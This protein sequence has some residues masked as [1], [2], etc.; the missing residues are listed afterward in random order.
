MSNIC[1]VF[2]ISH[3]YR[4]IKEDGILLLQWKYN[5][6]SYFFG[7]AKAQILWVANSWDLSLCNHT[8]YIIMKKLPCFSIHFLPALKEASL[9]SQSSSYSCLWFFFLSYQALL[10][11]FYISFFSWLQLTLKF[12]HLHFYMAP[13]WDYHK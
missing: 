8:K 5:H 6:M 11:D 3:T 12:L 7:P 4:G 1:S 9:I 2:S 10:S 13:F